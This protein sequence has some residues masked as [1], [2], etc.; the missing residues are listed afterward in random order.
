M[1][2]V[3]RP[4]DF[5]K[6]APTQHPHFLTQVV[7]QQPRGIPHDLVHAVLLQRGVVAEQPEVHQAPQDGVLARLGLGQRQQGR[8][9]LQREGRRQEGQ[10]KQRADQH[11]W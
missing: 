1:P 4:E 7:R 2:C 8:K 5:G 6:A 3:T 9:Q 10:H 11:V